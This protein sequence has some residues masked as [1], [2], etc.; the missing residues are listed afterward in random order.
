[1]QARTEVL[2]SGGKDN[3]DTINNNFSFT[4]IQ[5]IEKKYY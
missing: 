5:K 1:M 3:K 2:L 4:H